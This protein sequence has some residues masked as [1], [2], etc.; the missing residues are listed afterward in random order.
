MMVSQD[1]GLIEFTPL[2]YLQVKVGVRWVGRP[3]AGS[4]VGLC[5]VALQQCLLLPLPLLPC[6]TTGMHAYSTPPAGPGRAQ[7][8][9]PGAARPPAGSAVR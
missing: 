2:G 6:V 8:G 4:L 5:A 3:N 9:V 1:L 7:A